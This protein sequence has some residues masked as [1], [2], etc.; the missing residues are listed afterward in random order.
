LQTRTTAAD[1]GNAQGTVGPSL[2]F[3][4]AAQ[5]VGRAI[6]HTDQLLVSDFETRG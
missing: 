4:Q 1:H 5:V 3:E 6:E 2:P